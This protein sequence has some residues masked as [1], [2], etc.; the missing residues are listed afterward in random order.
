MQINRA[1]PVRQNININNYN[2][3]P[4]PHRI[5]E[6]NLVQVPLIQ[7]NINNNNR[8]NRMAESARAFP[9]KFSGSSTENG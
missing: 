7:L 5:Q 6:N 1:N 4:R 3:R 2:L 9:P 8:N